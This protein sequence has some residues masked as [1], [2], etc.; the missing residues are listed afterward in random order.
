MISLLFIL[1]GALLLLVG[2]V[3]IAPQVRVHQIEAKSGAAWIFRGGAG[4]L[5]LG[6]LWGLQRPIEPALGTVALIVGGATLFAALTIISH[7]RQQA[8]YKFS[9][10]LSLQVFVAGGVILLLAFFI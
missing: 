9:R 4:L 3:T 2:F 8:D 10:S 7:E 5:I 6:E 1:L